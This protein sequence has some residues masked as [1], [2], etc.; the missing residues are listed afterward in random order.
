MNAEKEDAGFRGC[1]LPLATVAL[2]QALRPV[3]HLFNIQTSHLPLAK[4]NSFR[5]QRA[6]VFDFCVALVL[7]T[8]LNILR[9]E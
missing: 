4:V 7:G 3:K 6:L 9:S 1:G 5:L 8:V 2:E